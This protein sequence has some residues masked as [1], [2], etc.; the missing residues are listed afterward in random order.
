MEV[1]QEK[2]QQ[3]LAARVLLNAKRDGLTQ[4]TWSAAFRANGSCD[5]SLV[6]KNVVID[7]Q[8]LLQAWEGVCDKHARHLPFLSVARP[9]EV[10]SLDQNK[11]EY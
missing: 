2:W 7:Y 9:Q 6:G 11:F 4:A 8:C 5:L 3:G 10:G 1:T